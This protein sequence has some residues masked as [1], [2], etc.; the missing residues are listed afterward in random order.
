M[1]THACI[2]KRGFNLAMVRLSDGAPAFTGCDGSG[3][4]LQGHMHA[5]IFC[6]CNPGQ[7]DLGE[8]DHVTVNAR[9]V[10]GRWDEAALRGWRGS[11]GRM[12]G[13]SRSSCRSWAARRTSPAVR[14]WPTPGDGFRAR[15]SC[16]LMP[17]RACPG[18]RL[19]GRGREHELSRLLGLAEFPEPMA[20]KGFHLALR[21]RPA[22]ATRLACGSHCLL[23]SA[24]GSSGGGQ[25]QPAVPGSG[26]DI[27]NKRP[28]MRIM[29]ETPMCLKTGHTRGQM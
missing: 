12:I 8:I 19:G 11:W 21:H 22:T 26:C 5:Y 14:C 1:L 4:P 27:A 13:M 29:I 15:S 16:P 28:D 24:P 10:F 17:T 18:A 7:G 2:W 9:S 23:R 25:P 20:G 3:K 6:E